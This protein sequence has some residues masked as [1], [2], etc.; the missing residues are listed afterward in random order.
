MTSKNEIELLII[1]IEETINLK[2]EL[3]KIE[4]FALNKKKISIEDI[5]D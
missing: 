3:L 4:S 5:R 2:N 1:L